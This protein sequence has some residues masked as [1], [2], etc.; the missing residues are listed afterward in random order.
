MVVVIDSRADL[1][2]EKIIL[3]KLRKYHFS[4]LFL[5]IA[6]VALLIWALVA[7]TLHILKPVPEHI[8]VEPKTKSAVFKAT[9]AVSDTVL[10]A[11]I[12]R[13]VIM[14]GGNAV[15]AA[16][17][18]TFCTGVT[19]PYATGLGGGGF[20]VIYMKETKKCIFLN[21]RETAPHRAKKDMFE[22]DQEAAQFGYTSIGVP[23]ELHGLWTAYKLY[24][25]KVVSWSDLVMPS[26][27][28]AKAFPNTL[29]IYNYLDRI[30]K[31][32]DRE[33]IQPLKNLYYDKYTDSYFNDGDILT[34]LELA[35]TL[36]MIAQSADPI[37]LF[38]NGTIA[39][40]IV[41]E[42]QLNGGIITLKDLQNY[43]TDI[44]EAL[45]SEIDGYRM[46]GPPPPSSWVITQMIPRIL[47]EQYSNKEYF[48]NTEFYHKLVEAEKLAYG[49]RG[50]LGDARHNERMMNLA[51]NM[52]SKSFI[53][54]I[55]LRV[56][57]E[58]EELEYYM[59][60][61]PGVNDAGTSHTS[62][63]DDDGNAVAITS[64][65]NMAFGSKMLSKFG[66]V[67]NNQMDDFS[68]PGL[69][70]H[71]GF[72]PS[73]ANY[74]RPGRRPMSSMSPTI[75]FHPGNGQV[76]MVTGAT[77]GSKI[78]SA[79][80]QTIT[81]AMLFNENAAKIVEAPRIHNQLTPF[82]THVEVGFSKRIA[83]KLEDK[84]DQEIKEVAEALAI[85][86]PITHDDSKYTA[87]A[88]YRR[89]TNNSPAGY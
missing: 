88:D 30:E 26:A 65:L 31:Y 19:L 74:I 73:P 24:G 79:T 28:L 64:T 87:A 41:E 3:A 23:G 62:I 43:R 78:I 68:T 58:A 80:A 42:M 37:Q 32:A 49:L 52:T 89:K 27:R 21:S 59:Q 75:I 48:Q 18:A 66:F 20:M 2:Q 11:E 46:C 36:E 1:A 35:K 54:S 72:E 51:I 38:Y 44:S 63:I 50:M 47:E 71:W 60:A 85:V 86:Y 70:N 82:E 4:V 84:Y 12:A 8:V 33:E 15:D 57:K 61:A 81:R 25:S 34:N 5:S 22:Y 77:G 10:C 67:Y 13:D 29:A 69:T 56:P 14:Q 7:T 9:A 55:S 53:Q 40:G 6:C 16:I 39:E 76:R 17:A 83:D 45:Y